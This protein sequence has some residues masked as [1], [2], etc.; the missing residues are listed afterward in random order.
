MVLLLA[1]L[2]PALLL[3]LLLIPAAP[4]SAAAPAAA[5][6]LDWNPEVVLTVSNAKQVASL[7]A[8]VACD[9]RKVKAT[10]VGEVAL[11]EP[12]ILGKGTTLVIA[13]AGGAEPAIAVASGDGHMLFVAEDNSELVISDMELRGG[14]AESGIRTC[15]GAIRGEQGS[16]LTLR[17]ATIARNRAAYGGGICMM[18]S[19]TL[20]VLDGTRVV[21]NDAIMYG[22]GIYMEDGATIH[23]AGDSFVGVNSADRDGGGVYFK[24]SYGGPSTLMLQQASV[25]RNAAGGSGGGI[26]IYGREGRALLSDGALVSGN[27]AAGE[28]GGI[29]GLEIA[30]EMEGTASV[31]DN[32]SGGD[33]GG[34]KAFSVELR[35]SA[36]IAR[37]VA[38]N[39]GGGAFV[40]GGWLEMHNSSSIVGNESRDTGGGVFINSILR[41]RVYGSLM[42]GGNSTLQAN[43]AH[44]GGGGVFLNDA[45]SLT[46]L[47]SS[48]VMGNQAGDG[49]GIHSKTQLFNIMDGH[50]RGKVILSGAI[51]IGENRARVTGGGI[52]IAGSVDVVMSGEIDISQNTAERFGGGLFGSGASILVTDGELILSGNLAGLDGGGLVFEYLDDYVLLDITAT[53]SVRVSDNRAAGKGGGLLLEDTT[54]MIAGSLRASDNE[55]LFGAGAY[56]DRSEI[57]L[58][59]A[60]D[61]Q[62]KGNSA[63]AQGGGCFLARGSTI[64]TEEKEPPAVEGEGPALQS[65]ISNSALE[66]GGGCYVAAGANLTLEHTLFSQNSAG[67]NGGGAFLEA[68]EVGFSCRGC[69]FTGDSASCCAA[70]ASKPQIPGASCLDIDAGLIGEQCCAAGQYFDGKQQCAACDDESMVCDVPGTTVS[71]MQLRKGYWRASVA[72]T[73]VLPCWNP[74]ACT[75]GTILGQEQTNEYCRE[76]YTGAYCAV[77]DQGYAQGTAGSCRKC[78]NA[79]TASAVIVLASCLALLAYFGWYC[80]NEVLGLDDAQDGVEAAQEA[81]PPSLFTLLKKVPWSKLRQPLIVFQVLTQFVA[82]S[83]VTFPPIYANFL[84]WL[85]VINLDFGWILSAG[86][87]W[88]T[89]FYQR[90]L[91]ATLTPLLVGVLLLISFVTLRRRVR[92]LEASQG[93]PATRLLQKILDMHQLFAMI[94]IFVIYSTVS[95]IVFQ[96]FSCDKLAVVGTQ[97]LRADYAIQCYTPL[98]RG[99]MIYSGIMIAVY[100]L[101]VPALFAAALWR[102]QERFRQGGTVDELRTD[103]DLKKS[104]FLWQPYKPKRHYWEVCEC[105]R[106]LMLTGILVFVFPGTPSQAATGSIIAVISLALIY[107][108][109]PHADSLDG[110]IYCLGCVIIFLSMLLALTSMAGVYHEHS[111]ISDTNAAVFAVVLVLLN[112]LMLLAAISQLLLVGYRTWDSVKGPLSTGLSSRSLVNKPPTP[113]ASDSTT[114]TIRSIDSMSSWSSVEDEEASPPQCHEFFGAPSE[115]GDSPPPPAPIA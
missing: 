36:G 9:A 78:S 73:V 24:S 77:C 74:H 43:T 26:M 70:T 55:A 42:M 72:S 32:E 54:A 84:S 76:G 110:R 25:A 65:F 11:P 115:D 100:P 3:L 81:S 102:Q 112:I 41:D 57:L 33:G 105:I 12:I 93:E 109:R 45:S 13:G 104:A 50:D 56:V 98:H 15:G 21:N 96:T 20:R 31:E 39:N 63:A 53:G 44:M 92:R 85:D 51:S 61:L 107:V 113:T 1:A 40:D 52:R 95:T 83:G 37:N 108:A 106:R 38:N 29:F 10:W 90:L 114:A 7:I 23:I 64:A 68:R 79:V 14:N 67:L 89:T 66:R 62:F 87:I 101:G 94:F 103:P 60:S 71:N 30:V 4:V 6:L 58:G 19:S 2:P 80:V 18:Q 17:R 47:D 16:S 49:G 46:M 97:W 88:R 82:I 86:C 59:R 34:I 8:V 111:G 28:G 75:G 35:D 99:F 91:L 22:G 48:S 27:I 5:C 69:S